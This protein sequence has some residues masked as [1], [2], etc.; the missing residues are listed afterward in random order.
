MSFRGPFTKVQYNWYKRNAFVVKLTVI[1][2]KQLLYTT[3]FK[4][5]E[6]A[7]RLSVSYY[8]LIKR[9]QIKFGC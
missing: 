4:T 2:Y 3:E 8:Q 5:S 6:E 9:D 7:K 1:Q